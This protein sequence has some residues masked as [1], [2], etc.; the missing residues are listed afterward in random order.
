[1]W[2]GCKRGMRWDGSTQRVSHGQI[3]GSGGEEQGM[4]NSTHCSFSKCRR[5][6]AAFLVPVQTWEAQLWL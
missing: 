6:S 2:E 1:M 4:F 5:D 3:A